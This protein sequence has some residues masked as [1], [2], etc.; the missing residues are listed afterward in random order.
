M[1]IHVKQLAMN[2]LMAFHIQQLFVIMPIICFGTNITVEYHR[3]SPVGFSKPVIKSQNLKF[4][5][6]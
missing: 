4:K 2:V 3:N 1:S 6:C 5:I